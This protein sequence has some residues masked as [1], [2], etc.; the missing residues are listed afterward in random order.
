MQ[1]KPLHWLIIIWR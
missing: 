1:G